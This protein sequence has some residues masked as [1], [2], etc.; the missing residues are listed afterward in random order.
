MI[1]VKIKGGL[2]NQMFQYAMA[3]K[4]QTEL[5]IDQIGLD[6]TRVNADRQRE[7]SL[8]HFRLRDHAIVLDENAARTVTRLQEDLAG[9]L[10]SYFVAG[11]P[12]EVAA[13]REKMMEKLFFLFG[14]VQKDHDAGIGNRALLKMHK[15]IFVN[16]WFQDA[17]A[18]ESIRDILLADFETAQEMP[19]EV[20][21]MGRRMEETESVCVHIRRGDYVNHPQFG[22]CTEDYYCRAMDRMA[23]KLA[24][25]VFYI[26]SDDLEEVR[27]MPFPGPVVFDD[28]GHDNYESLYLMSK[29]K[30]FIMSNS[31]FSW[32]GQFLSPTDDKIVIAPDRWCNGGDRYRTLYSDRW[33]LL[34]V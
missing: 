14:I 10:V 8:H 7:F 9:R 2:G 15:N 24:Q 29:C 12:E 5:G 28:P 4:L 17:K 27:A 16:G 31:T 6:I 21:K 13:A 34:S 32:W 26:F 1:V 23:E 33:T 11:R 25:P 30:H 19:E 22:I 18:V 3:R 20:K